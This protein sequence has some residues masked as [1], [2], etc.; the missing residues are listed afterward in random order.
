VKETRLVNLKIKKQLQ[1]AEAI[2]AAV[3]TER[4]K[5]ISNYNVPH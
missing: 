3:Q 5:F 1:V 2:L 4:E